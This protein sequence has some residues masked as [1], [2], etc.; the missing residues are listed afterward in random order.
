M[1]YYGNRA[2]WI[3]A[4]FSAKRFS[5]FTRNYSFPYNFMVGNWGVREDTIGLI[6]NVINPASWPTFV[7]EHLPARF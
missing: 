6:D 5:F 2:P 3:T 7:I 1:S 4:Y